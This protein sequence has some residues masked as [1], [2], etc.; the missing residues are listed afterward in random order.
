MSEELHWIVEPPGI[1][2]GYNLLHRIGLDRNKR[3]QFLRHPHFAAN[4]ASREKQDSRALAPTYVT[5]PLKFFEP[6]VMR[7][8]ERSLSSIDKAAID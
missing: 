8:F 3:D 4:A 7:L 5:A 1:F 2:R 6:I